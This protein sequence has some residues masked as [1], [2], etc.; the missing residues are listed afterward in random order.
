M[1]AGRICSRVF[2]TAF[3][4]ETV[5]AAAERMREHEVGTLVVVE[6]GATAEAR[7]MITDRDI[8]LRCVALGLDP[9]ATRVAAVMTAPVATVDE[10]T[11]VEAAAEEMARAGIRR[12]VVT[13]PGRKAVGVLALDDILD[14]VIEELGPLAKLLDKQR[15]SVPA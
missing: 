4:G 5:R 3:P 14:L 8:A 11:P 10:D 2:A 15:P 7:G 9:E 1:S 6:P 13:G 12:L